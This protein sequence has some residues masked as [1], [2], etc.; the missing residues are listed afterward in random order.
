M[1]G[2][3]AR[4]AITG[5]HGFIGSALVESLERD[6]HEVVRVA[7]DDIR[8]QVFDG[9][10]AVVH[11]AGEPIGARR[12][13]PEQKRRILD[14]RTERTTSV[15]TVLATMHDGPRVLV[16]GSAVGYHRPPADMPAPDVTELA[17]GSREATSLSSRHC[18]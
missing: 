1:P 16:S 15:A 10:E 5:S 12:W 9:A 11:L 13:S 3:P 18:A 17:A 4:V 8:A 14:S 6:D 7:R 2:C